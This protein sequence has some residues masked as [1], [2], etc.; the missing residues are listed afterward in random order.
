VF[1]LGTQR[2]LSYESTNWSLPVILGIGLSPR[3]VSNSGML[4]GIVPGT[5]VLNDLTPPITRD[6]A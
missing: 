6:A 1:D 5:A 2:A 4:V 3:N